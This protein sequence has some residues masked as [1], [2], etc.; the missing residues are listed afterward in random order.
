[1]KH[2]IYEKSGLI[3]LSDRLL[4]AVRRYLIKYRLLT[5]FRVFR[6]VIHFGPW[7][8]LPQFL[9]QMLRPVARNPCE[10]HISL[11]GQLD[12]KAIADEIRNNSVAIAGVLPPYFVNQMQIITD[13]LPVDHYQKMQ[14]IDENVRRLSEDAGIKN[15]LREYF[16]CEPVLLEATLG[17][18]G[19]HEVHGISGQNSFHFD[20]A[21]WQSLNVFVYLSDMAEKSSC[22]IVACGS[23]RKKTLRD[24]FRDCPLTE[25]E[26][27]ARF[28][29][30]IKVITGVAGTVFFENTEAFH[31]RYP[32]NERRVMLN[33]LYASHRN[34]LSHG[35]ASRDHLKRRAQAYAK[36]HAMKS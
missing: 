1:M 26:A 34:W 6:L 16:K 28:G 25:S 22:H 13:R 36:L 23:H 2:G 3:D 18:N 31:R 11:L 5:F 15:V 9:I 8:P 21:G 32:G 33:L 19:S 30:A 20:Y 27:R 12:I 17:V 14:H 7:R 35:R 29:D 10:E 4:N 24:L